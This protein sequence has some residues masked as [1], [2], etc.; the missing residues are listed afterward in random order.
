MFITC[1]SVD[2]E[3][4]K[5]QTDVSRF[6]KKFLD[7]NVNDEKL[8]LK[9]LIVNAYDALE[10]LHFDFSKV[11]PQLDDPSD[12]SIKIVIGLRVYRCMFLI[13]GNIIW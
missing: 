2:V 13:C 9:A 5:F 6:I 12:L 7:V 8:L 11:D 10:R 1:D 4:Y 3:T